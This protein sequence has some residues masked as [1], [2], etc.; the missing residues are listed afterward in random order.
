MDCCL[1]VAWGASG[2]L[3]SVCSRFVAQGCLALHLS[4]SSACMITI[5]APQLLCHLCAGADTKHRPVCLG[6]SQSAVGHTHAS[7]A[8]AS[9]GMHSAE[10][11]CGPA[12]RRQLRCSILRVVPSSLVRL[13]CGQIGDVG[14]VDRILGRHY[15]NWCCCRR[16]LFSF[17]FC[18]CGQDTLGLSVHVGAYPAGM[19]VPTLQAPRA[20]FGMC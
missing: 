18:T 20:F 7:C 6:T 14:D 8:T 17:C 3:G 11:A 12:A 13:C 15:L 1:F 16:V 4:C 9:S 5:D 19:W 2:V 10:L